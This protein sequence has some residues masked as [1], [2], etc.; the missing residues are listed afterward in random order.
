MKEDR[1][2]STL[3][4]LSPSEALSLSNNTFPSLSGELEAVPRASRGQRIVGFPSDF[5]MSVEERGQPRS[6]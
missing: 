6:P 2:G 1:F 4:G 3:Q 5:A